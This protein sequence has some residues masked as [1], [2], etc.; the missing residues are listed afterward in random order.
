[1]GDIA[2]SLDQIELESSAHHVLIRGH[3][4][5]Q[6]ESMVHFESPRRVD[7]YR[8]PS[9]SS[10][11]L[12]YIDKRSQTRTRR[13]AKLGSAR[14]SERRGRPAPRTTGA[15]TEKN[16]RESGG[17]R[18]AR[19][20]LARRGPMLASVVVVAADADGRHRGRACGDRASKE[21]ERRPRA[22]A[23][24]HLPRRRRRIE[25]WS[26]APRASRASPRARSAAPL[27][28]GRRRRTPIDGGR[29][30]AAARPVASRRARPRARTAHACV[31][32]RAVF[33]IA[34]PR[35]RR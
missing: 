24:A 13:L 8:H 9:P 3:Q 5:L 22:R 16:E 20:E 32:A 18:A 34:L 19:D 2:P 35:A 7:R 15:T 33:R 6:V 12:Y 27:R 30:R 10:T 14:A 1:M 11:I 17:G 28:P 4:E 31:R 29:R 23:G 25:R 21:K 26:P